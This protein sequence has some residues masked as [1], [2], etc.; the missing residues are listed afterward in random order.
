MA[1][2]IHFTLLIVFLNATL[3]NAFDEDYLI[4]QYSYV[5]SSAGQQLEISF[6][7]SSLFG[8]ILQSFIGSTFPASEDDLKDDD[9]EVYR[10]AGHRGFLPALS[11]ARL[12]SISIILNNDREE[13]DQSPVS[14]SNESRTIIFGHIREHLHRFHMF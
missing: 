10:R 6:L 11:S 1:R 9:P 4:R 13:P 14:S 12:V 5:Q 3:F 7:S 8:F 2:L